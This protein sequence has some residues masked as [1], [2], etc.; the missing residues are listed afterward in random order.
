VEPTLLIGEI[1]TRL[2]AFDPSI[3]VKETHRFK[4]LSNSKADDAKK[5]MRT[6]KDVSIGRPQACQGATEKELLAAGIVGL[7]ETA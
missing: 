5:V 7:Y 1:M 3:T 4:W 2:K 6:F